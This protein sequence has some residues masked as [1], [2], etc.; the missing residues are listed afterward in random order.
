[1]TQVT[2]S[3]SQIKAIQ[4]IN[5]WVANPDRPK[6]LILK[7]GAGRG[8]TFLLAN[9]HNNTLSPFHTSL[10]KHFPFVA[11]TATTHVAIE[12]LIN[13]SIVD[14]L[15]PEVSTLHSALGISP[16]TN[17]YMK[18]TRNPSKFANSSYLFSN[19]LSN[20]HMKGLLIVDEAYRIDE[21]LYNIMV[22]RYPNMCFLFLGDPFQTPP[23]GSSVAYIETIPD[24][25]KEVFELVHPMRFKGDDLSDT[26]ENLL[27]ATKFQ[28]PSWYDVLPPKDQTGDVCWKKYSYAQSFLNA[29][30]GSDL[31]TQNFSFVCGTRKAADYFNKYIVDTRK[32]NQQCEVY[33]KETPITE[34]TFNFKKE[35]FEAVSY[36]E[37]L[38]NFLANPMV[39]TADKKKLK[40]LTTDNGKEYLFIIGDEGKG[41]S[42][43]SLSVLHGLCRKYNNL[44]YIFRMN[45]AKTIH[46]AQ[47]ITSEVVFVDMPSIKRWQDVDMRRRLTYTAASR[48]ST[49]L[50]FL[51]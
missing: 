21:E 31:A 17:S 19:T 5:N 18:S 39:K 6:H 44:A 51:E 40:L 35:G 43:A 28:E 32:K 48:S 20:T 29:R 16:S 47:G 14:T 2:Y 7:A 36:P 3:S 45:I 30:C 26:V 37:I 49:E 41:L 4:I 27:L 22:Y 1:M 50:Y 8:K 10:R 9:M 13:Q 38:N 15:T 42:G 33:T 11:Y 46:T 23:V 25:E 12:Q 34:Y 24:D